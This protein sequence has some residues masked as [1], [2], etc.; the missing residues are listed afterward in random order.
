MG[1][2]SGLFTAVVACA[3][4]AAALAADAVI[5]PD[6]EGF[7]GREVRII[8]R[9]SLSKGHTG[10][11]HGV[12]LPDFAARR[13]DG[14]A[15]AGR[16]VEAL[17][18]LHPP[19][20]FGH[21]DPDREYLA[22]PVLVTESCELLGDDTPRSERIE[23]LDRKRLETA[24]PPW[25]A[26]VYV[27]VNERGVFPTAQ[28]VLERFGETLRSKGWPCPTD[29]SLNLWAELEYH[30]EGESYSDPDASASNWYF[31][32]LRLRIGA[33]AL[34][35]DDRGSGRRVLLDRRCRIPYRKRGDA[36]A[37]NL[38]E[39][40]SDLVP[41]Y[42]PGSTLRYPDAIDLP[43]LD[44]EGA[45]PELWRFDLTPPPADSSLR[46]ELLDL[47]E[48]LKG[49]TRREGVPSLPRRAFVRYVP[50]MLEG[51][52]EEEHF[53]QWDPRL[54]SLTVLEYGPVAR[55]RAV[56]SLMALRGDDSL[57]EANWRFGSSD[58]DRVVECWWSAT[59]PPRVSKLSTAASIAFV[60]DAIVVA[61]VAPAQ[62]STL[63]GSFFE[64]LESD[65]PSDVRN[66]P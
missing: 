40:L 63:L 37:F 42:P 2:T 26:S 48:R 11:V 57:A 3:C 18:V 10:E 35:P 62:F 33:V 14:Q 34:T 13:G 58:D 66:P 21:E 47:L 17:G 29:S 54:V 64:G 61:F 9:F 60:G 1:F 56:A 39:V 24:L 45:T 50:R 41:H 52:P 27:E 32:V 44:H 25:F 65:D 6:L 4:C 46:N 36:A 38:Q 15:Y 8:G 20:G 19:G 22:G 28:Q 12:L 51:N 55:D 53:N 59:R 23:T 31:G 16:W 5:P 43:W 49:L 7:Y 30:I